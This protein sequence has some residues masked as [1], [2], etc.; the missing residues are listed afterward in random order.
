[1]AIESSDGERGVRFTPSN[2]RE[3]APEVRIVT[4]SIYTSGTNKMGAREVLEVLLKLNP[5][6]GDETRNRVFRQIIYYTQMLAEMGPESV[7]VIQEFLKKNQDVDYAG[8]L[9]NASG[10]RVG[11]H[12]GAAFA[13]RNVT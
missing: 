8:D 10:E 2:N 6:A 3:T 9:I 5:S 12:G 1:A 11:R 13:S 7:P 4:R